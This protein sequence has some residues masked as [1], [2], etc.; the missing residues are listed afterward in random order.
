MLTRDLK[1]STDNLVVHGKLIV[2]LSTNLQAP[3]TSSGSRPPPTTTNTMSSTTSTSQFPGAGAPSQSSLGPPARSSPAPSRTTTSNGEPPRTSL[4]APSGA[5]PAT[6]GNRPAGQL[7]SFEDSQGRLP[8]GWE[9][10]EDRKANRTSPTASLLL[11][12]AARQTDP[13]I[14]RPTL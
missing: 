3:A 14:N 5:P 6:N 10:R 11:H 9:R 8:A 13:P 2:N 1:K 4:S 12:A 7:S